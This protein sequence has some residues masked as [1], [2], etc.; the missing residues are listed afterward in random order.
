MKYFK[1]KF[2]YYSRKC[3]EVRKELKLLKCL[4]VSYWFAFVL[5]GVTFICYDIEKC[6]NVSLFCSLMFKV[7]TIVYCAY[8]FTLFLLMPIIRNH[9]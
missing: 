3:F 8:C 6:F 2:N 7:I 4:P 5:F 9:F 1:D